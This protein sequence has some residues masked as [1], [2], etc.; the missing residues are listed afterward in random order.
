M[1][2]RLAVE[3]VEVAKVA[4]ELLQLPPLL[5]SSIASELRPSQGWK[6]PVACTG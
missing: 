6:R 1:L 4:V 2:S 5:S 3:A